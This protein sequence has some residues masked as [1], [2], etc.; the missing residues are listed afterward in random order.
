MIY[1]EFTYAFHS[2]PRV[3]K[4]QQIARSYPNFDW[5]PIK[6]PLTIFAGYF[7]S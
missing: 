7:P 4:L 2:D 5:S 6:F 3:C 1:L